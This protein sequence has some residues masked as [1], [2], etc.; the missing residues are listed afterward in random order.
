MKLIL[1]NKNN[2]TLD[3]LNNRDKFVLKAAVGL[4]GI[5]TSISE[6]ESPYVDGTKADNV[7]A[8]P[9]GIELTFKLVG[10]VKESIDYITSYI[11]SKQ[12]V[13]LTEEENGHEITVKGRVTVLPYT[14][15]MRSCELVV[16]IYCPQPY[17]EDLNYLVGV[18]AE[19]I[20]LLNFP[21]EGQY[22]TV[23]GRPFGLIDTSLEKTFVNDGDVEVGMLINL[24]ALGELVNPRISC[25]T[26]EQ[27]GFYMQLN[28]TLS[29]NDEV[30]I[31]TK[32]KEK[33]ITIN[34]LEEYNGTPVLE[35]LEFVGTDWLQLEQGENTFNA[36]AEKGS[37]NIYF[38]IAYKGRYE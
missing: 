22:F 14:R 15:M 32:K 1:T 17:W 30:R 23:T 38:S 37:G 34:G 12:I 4:H 28:M 26:G 10:D 8:L 24:I 19:K 21:Q 13:T 29:S 33:Y 27:N 6:S 31:N 2:Q 7:K 20:D 5:E 25:S 9:R 11:K 3:L 36:T 35:Y 16:S 18:I